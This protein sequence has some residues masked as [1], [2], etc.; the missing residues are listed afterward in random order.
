MNLR[1]KLIEANYV[2]RGDDGPLLEKQCGFSCDHCTLIDGEKND[3]PSY[4]ICE[5]FKIRVG[6][7]DSCRYYS[8]KEFRENCLGLARAIGLKTEKEKQAEQKMQE[9]TK[10]G[11]GCALCILAVI[12]VVVY[13]IVR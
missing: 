6:M 2:H 3:R 4:R 9:N 11:T 10:S 12:I 1:D 8:D 7:Y 5:K 13:L